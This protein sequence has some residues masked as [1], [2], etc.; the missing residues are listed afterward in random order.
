V[1]DDAPSVFDRAA[2]RNLLRL[3]D[4]VVSRD[5]LRRLGARDHDLERLLRRR[6]LTVVRSGVYVDHTGP[7][8][9][10]QRAWAAVLESW[11]AALAG[12]SALRAA[13]GPGW[14][15]HRDDDPIEIAVALSRTLVVRPGVSIRRMAGLQARVR[16]NASPPRVREEEA[17][18]DVVI[19]AGDAWNQIEQLAQA[20]RARLTTAERLRAAMDARLRVPRRRW[21][22]EVLT[23][24]ADGTQSV[25]EHGYLH[26]VERAHGLPRA[27]RQVVDE[28]ARGRVYRDARYTPYGVDVEL[29]GRLWHDGPTQR[30]IDL[31][32][33]LESATTG[34]VTV[35]LG[36]GQVYDR[37]CRTAYALA[38]VLKARGWARTPTRCADCV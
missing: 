11:P 20:C 27:E 23:D 24:L 36:W 19:G 35:R 10:Q 30:D 22:R 18:I 4:G 21:L 33:D 15:G 2:A 8:T 9:W 7:P 14:R 32:R 1:P 29:D 37:P 12:R 38:R 6:D 28:T 3:Q 26:R 34:R 16:W 13:A 25:L 5:Q 17:V 31:D